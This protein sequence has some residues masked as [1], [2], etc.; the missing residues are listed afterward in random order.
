MKSF[1]SLFPRSVRTLWGGLML[2]LLLSLPGALTALAGT[3]SPITI[4]PAA[5]PAPVTGAGYSLTVTATGG[6]APYVWSAPLAPLP[7]G[8]SLNAATGVVSG[9]PT[10]PGNAV[11]FLRVT[12]AKGLTTQRGWNVL[13]GAGSGGPTPPPPQPTPYTVTV[14]NGTANN[15]AS[16]SFAP[17]TV[18]TVAAAPA[19]AGQ[20]FKQWSGGVAFANA[21]ASTTSFTMPAANVTVAAG[22]YTPAP[23]PQ[24]VAGHPRLWINQGDLARLRGWATPGNTVYRDLR[25]TLATATQAHAR[26]FPDGQHPATPYPDPGD[27]NAYAGANIGQDIVSEQHAL[28]LAFFALIDPDPAARLQHAQR[29]RQL[30][31]HVLDEAVKGHLKDAPFR[32]PIYAIYNR[33]NS[34]GE[35]WPL[36]VDWLQG[37]TDAN[38]AVVPVF[39]ALDR[40]TIRQTFLL[41]ANDCLNAYIC[42]GD[43]PAPIGV[44]N[45]PALLPGGNAHRIAANNY[46]L[47]H[48]RL[49]TMMPLAV[50]PA[51]DPAIVATIPEAVLG[52]TLRS[53]LAN[54]TGA[55]LYQ[56]YAM[57]GDPAA[58]RAAYGL[59]ATAQVGLASGGLPPEGG[60]Y[61]HSYAYVFGQLLALQTAGFADPQLAGPQIAL[62]TAPV[63]DRFVQGYVSQFVPQ[64]KVDP[65]QPYLGPVYQMANYG[66]LLRLW[67]TPDVTHTFGLL[68]L[69]GQKQGDPRHLN[70]A[71]WVALHAVEGGAAGL[72]ARITNPWSTPEA[73]LNFLLFDPA[74]PAPVDPRPAWP[75]GFFDAGIGRL[76]ART[77]WSPAASLFAFRSGWETINHQNTDAGLFE[78]YRKGEWLTKELSNYDNDDNGQSSIWKNSLALKNWCS[79]GTPYLNWFE[80]AFWTHGSQWNNGQSAGDPVTTASFGPGYAFAATD[81]TKLYNR[82]S[83]FTPENACLDIQHASRAILWLDGDTVVVYDR[84][85]SLHAGLFKRFNLNFAL[86]PQIDSAARQ[87]VATTPGGQK[88]HVQTLLPNTPTTVLSYVAEGGTLTNIAQLET[89]TGRLVVED[90][91]NPADIRFLHVVQGVDNGSVP[92]TAATKLASDAGAATAYT[93]A[94]VGASAALFPDRIATPSAGTAYTVPATV[95]KHFV[96]G[97]DP[98]ARYAVAV[99][100]AG[101]SVQVTITP[102]GNVAPDSAG[103]ILLNLAG[104][105][106]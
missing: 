87:A 37:V 78:L 68:A 71:R 5:I 105:L 45:S 33:G 15:V 41:W 51:D 73:I 106:P 53:Y 7:A 13:I 88:V 42:G 1:P 2:R 29:A 55:W 31:M 74:A 19:P 26:C 70:A 30:L 62:A 95:V 90:T 20:Y 93:G 16:G 14:T 22:Y 82:P 75:T 59:P 49:I 98:Q 65:R 79:A 85:T 76:V 63:W 66:D 92:V 67:I 101:A 35:S 17:G 99:T 52:N 9:T 6:T 69:L 32:D 81:M 18:I 36:I 43:H 91:A 104:T 103:V 102:G 86:P 39:T 24:P 61:G 100:A 94:I 34:A 44:T 4:A 84:A 54:A 40:A 72:S 58:V 46:Y 28:V 47:N 27:I 38:G 8:L 96:A 21:F 57:Y 23:I 12:D 97:F 89:M 56:Q 60:L 10:T 77:D 50:D 3:P 11:I 64:Q 25:V 80:Q 83:P 48:A